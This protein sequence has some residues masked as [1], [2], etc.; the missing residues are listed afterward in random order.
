[1]PPF[2]YVLIEGEATFE[3]NPP[4]MK[5]WATRIAARYMGEELADS[6][7]QRNA[8]PGEW[9]VRIRPTNIVSE[10]DVAA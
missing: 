8:V 2:S 4:D 10:K 5:Y 3:E 7:G 9:L 6:Y 1:T